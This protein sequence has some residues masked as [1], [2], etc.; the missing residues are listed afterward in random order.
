MNSKTENYQFAT[1]PP[2][3]MAIYRLLKS[4]TIIVILCFL[5]LILAFIV[6]TNSRRQSLTPT[7]NLPPVQSL[8][9]T[10]KSLVAAPD[11]SQISSQLN[12]LPARLNVHQIEPAIISHQEAIDLAIK[13]DFHQEPQIIQGFNIGPVYSWQTDQQYLTITTEKGNIDYGLD[14]LRQKVSLTGKLPSQE[15]IIQ[16][17]N[18]FLEDNILPFPENISHEIIKTEYYILD[19]SVFT[20]VS[21]IEEAQITLVSYSLKLNGIPLCNYY[22]D[23]ILLN[24]FIG[25]GPR[26][27]KINYQ[28]PFNR[29]LSSLEYP[30]I[31]PNQLLETIK[32]R[33]E[34]TSLSKGG[35]SIPD[36]FEHQQIKE[37]SFNQIKPAY[38][39]PEKPTGTLQPVFL[40]TGTGKLPD[41]DF[42]STTIIPALDSQYYLN[43]SPTP[44]K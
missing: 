35:Y 21:S 11:T 44:K 26:I 22:G 38:F 36:P 5:A 32:S 40:I 25:P 9:V 34:I 1:I 30:L 8:E 37:I 2:T 28:K 10:Q 3:K 41:T 15:E 19:S 7:E 13:F 12:Q 43:L 24:I 18:N 14:L 20:P 6:I 31:Q 42:T 23:E 39:L 17:T 33:P 16:T 4:K 29:I 27:I